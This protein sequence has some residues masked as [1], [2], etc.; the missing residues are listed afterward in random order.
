MKHQEAAGVQHL[1]QDQLRSL[2][3]Q[4]VIKSFPKNTIM[5]S[6]GDET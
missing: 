3:T 4:G 5:V 6:E 2:S 1:N